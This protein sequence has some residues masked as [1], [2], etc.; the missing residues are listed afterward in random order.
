MAKNVKRADSGIR[1]SRRSK[2]IV[3]TLVIVFALIIAAFFVYI[4]GLLP[5]VM[6]GVKI[7][8]TVNGVVTNID[9]ISVAETNYHYYQDS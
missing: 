4:S 9:N 6:T 1:A 7:N 8:K 5:K 2:A 3:T